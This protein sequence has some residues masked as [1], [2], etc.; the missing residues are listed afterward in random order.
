[1]TLPSWCVFIAFAHAV[2]TT[3]TLPLP[4]TNSQASKWDTVHAS[5]RE[6]HRAIV[7]RYD[8]DR[9]ELALVPVLSCIGKCFGKNTLQ[10]ETRVYCEKSLCRTN[11]VRV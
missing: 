8:G 3:T 6:G 7:I 2:C 10:K 11:F 4:L 5:A 9:R 1:L